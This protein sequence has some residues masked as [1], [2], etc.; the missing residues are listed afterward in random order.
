MNLLKHI[1]LLSLFASPI[2]GWAQG[3]SSLSNRPIDSVDVV[4]IYKPKV[5]ESVKIGIYPKLEEPAAPPISYN[6]SFPNISYQPKAVYS[7]IDPVYLKKEK[8]EDLYD[9]YIQCGLGNYLTTFLDANIFNTQDKY[10]SYGLNIKHH[11][12][13][14]SRIPYQGLFSENG[15]TAFGKREKGG[16]LFGKIDYNRQ[17]V[18]NYGYDS[19]IYEFDLKDI[20]Q[21]YNDINAQAIWSSSRRG[22]KNE[23]SLGFDLFDRVD[24]NE[25]TLSAANNSEFR[26]GNNSFNLD[27]DVWFNSMTRDTIYNRLL[28]TVSP[29]YVFRYEKY[30]IDLGANMT[31]VSDSNTSKLLFSPNIHAYT[32]L[33]P[34]KLR[35]YVG[36]SGGVDKSN[37]RSMV[38]LNPFIQRDLEYRNPF[39]RF[40][41]YVGMNGNFKRYIEYGIRLSQ[42]LVTDQYFFVNDTNDTRN[43]LAVYTDRFSTFKFS[44]ELK[45]DVNQNID[46]GVA[47]TVY[48]YNV[49]GIT[50]AYHLPAYDAKAFATVRLMDKL[51]V[52]G[53]WFAIGSRQAGNIALQDE[54]RLTPIND[55]NVGA[56]YRYKK[57]ISA[58]LNVQNIL[59]QHYQLW[60]HY[61]SQG[62]NFM[63]GITISL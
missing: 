36:I 56:E 37:M 35:A 34:K 7:P 30:Y 33:V 25:L 46:I 54:G 4:T 59:N 39:K 61:P 13:S 31:Y 62:L 48:S 51:Y 52:S 28:A 27:L 49:N 26:A 5:A 44:G 47:A 20:A 57:N 53:A 16:T 8:A 14:N 18:H 42:M 24:A 43:F 23:F 63:A 11:A 60:N 40:E 2:I 41:A 17:V 10:Y 9:N 29:S 45:V 6:Y 12:S 55:I 22:V 58:F 19:S 32:Y 1:I 38:A 50:K 3:D 15:V 21:I